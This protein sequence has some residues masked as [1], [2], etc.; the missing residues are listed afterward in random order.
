MGWVMVCVRILRTQQRVKNR[1]QLTS[2]RGDGD[3]AFC[4]LGSCR[5]EVIILWLTM[6]KQCFL[7]VVLAQSGFQIPFVGNVVSLPLGGG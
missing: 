1:C 3:L 6:I 7:L 2:F 5:F 4:G